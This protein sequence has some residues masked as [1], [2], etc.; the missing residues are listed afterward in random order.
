MIYLKLFISLKNIINGVPSVH[1][2]NLKLTFSL[3]YQMYHMLLAQRTVCRAR[4]VIILPLRFIHSF[5]IFICNIFR[6]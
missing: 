6:S 2:S 1:P 5:Q 4:L 3:Q